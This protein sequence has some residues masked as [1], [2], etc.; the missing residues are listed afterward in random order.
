MDAT[1]RELSKNIKNN[2]IHYKIKI[3]NLVK[4]LVPVARKKDTVLNYSIV[5]PD[6]KGK[7]G[8]FICRK[9]VS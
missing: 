5:Y 8:I 2:S 9:D 7:V 1:L 4:E 3:A 6:N